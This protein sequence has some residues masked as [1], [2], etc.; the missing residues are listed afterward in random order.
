M[1]GNVLEGNDEGNGMVGRGGKER[2][3][4]GRGGLE[5]DG[6]MGREERRGHIGRARWEDE[7]R[8]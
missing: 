6:L 3:G 8:G 1:G 5:A 4:V 2:G 7:G